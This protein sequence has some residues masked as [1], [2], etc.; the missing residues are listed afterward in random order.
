MVVSIWLIMV[1][2]LIKKVRFSPPQPNVNYDGKVIAIEEAQREWKEIFIKGKKAGYTVSIL[3]PFDDG[4]YIQ[5][6][7]FLKLNLMGMGRDL[8]TITQTRVDNQFLLKVFILKYN[9]FCT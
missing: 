7:I 6:E 1:G 9:I 8:Y 4:Y 3:N 2:L 5:E